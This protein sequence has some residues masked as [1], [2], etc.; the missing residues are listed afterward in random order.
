MQAR[1]R[2]TNSSVLPVY[3]PVLTPGTQTDNSEGLSLKDNQ[4]NH[5]HNTRQKSEAMVH[6]QQITGEQTLIT[7]SGIRSHLHCDL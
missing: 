6:V 7:Q 3:A 4:Q 5:R 1:L 2:S